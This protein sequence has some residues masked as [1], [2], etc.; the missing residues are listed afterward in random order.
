MSDDDVDLRAAAQR[1][2]DRWRPG[3]VDDA[4]RVCRAWLAANPGPDICQYCPE[5][6][7]FWVGG[8]TA[9]SNH[10]D[11]LLDDRKRKNTT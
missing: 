6:A 2:V 5:E 7:C 10:I 4:Y 11:T 9:C 1:V 3:G 8:D